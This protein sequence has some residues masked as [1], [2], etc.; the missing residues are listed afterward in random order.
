MWGVNQDIVERQVAMQSHGED[1]GGYPRC[2]TQ[3]CRSDWHE[4]AS[5]RDN[6]GYDSC[7][8]GKI[9]SEICHGGVSGFAEN[10][11]LSEALS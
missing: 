3:G 9:G 5:G 7:V 4:G 6:T 8:S 1:S 10:L 11:L 2:D